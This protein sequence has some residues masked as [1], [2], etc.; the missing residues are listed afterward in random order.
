MPLL[1]D[2]N[3]D[4]KEELGTKRVFRTDLAQLKSNE[5]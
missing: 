2:G 4:F 3:T 5:F 1:P